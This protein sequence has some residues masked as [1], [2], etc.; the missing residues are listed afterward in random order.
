MDG[1]KS[2]YA[3]SDPEASYCQGMNFLAGFLL[4]LTTEEVELIF[5]QAEYYGLIFF[6]PACLRDAGGAHA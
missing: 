5:F 3:I 1:C 2:R 6:C 4:T